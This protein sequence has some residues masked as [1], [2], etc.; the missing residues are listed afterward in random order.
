M[1]WLRLA[2]Q[3]STCLHVVKDCAD[4]THSTS[5]SRAARN[6]FALDVAPSETEAETE[7][8]V[9]PLKG[10]CACGPS[11][12]CLPMVFCG[13]PQWQS[14][15]ALQRRNGAVHSSQCPTHTQQH[16]THRKGA[17]LAQQSVRG[18]GNTDRHGGHTQ[19]TGDGKCTSRTACECENGCGLW[20]VDT[21]D[22]EHCD[23]GKG[24]PSHA[25]DWHGKDK[26]SPR[27]ALAR[28]PTRTRL[29]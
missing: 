27:R 25:C 24:E 14:R 20:T 23:C 6:P 21:A 17:G 11:L 9:A 1:C 29:W 26:N 28:A 16:P 7:V 5:E 8:G 12:Q 3:P 10:N 13:V 2:G 4:C 19:S 15:L 18:T 22:N